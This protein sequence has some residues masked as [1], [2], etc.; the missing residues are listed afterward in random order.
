MQPIRGPFLS[1]FRTAAGLLA[2]AVSAAA[3]A[4]T[5]YKWVDERGVVNYGN[6]DVPKTREVSVVDTT[7]QVASQPVAKM[8]DAPTRPARLSDADML[9]EELMRS[10]E[11]IARLRQNAAPG[12]KSNSGRGTESFA[13]WR[14]ECEQQRRAD[15][16]E[17]TYAAQNQAGAISRQPAA[18]RQPVSYVPKPILNK[19]EP[20][21]VQIAGASRT[22]PQAAG[23]NAVVTIQ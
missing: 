14:E 21:T 2:L 9:R 1:I 8:R 16:D 19:P 20:G 3:P 23:A 4:Q 22:V 15:C 12:A 11:E 13:T 18:A 7:P 10:R 17:A 5:I 6:A